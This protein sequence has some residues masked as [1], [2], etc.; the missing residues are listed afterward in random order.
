MWGFYCPEGTGARDDLK[1]G[2]WHHSTRTSISSMVIEPIEKVQATAASSSRS[3]YSSLMFPYVPLLICGVYHSCEGKWYRQVCTPWSIVQSKNMQNSYRWN[4]NMWLVGF[5]P[6]YL[7][8]FN[9]FT[10]DILVQTEAYSHAISLL[11]ISSAFVEEL[12]TACS[13]LFATKFEASA[14]ARRRLRHEKDFYLAQ[15]VGVLQDFPAM[16]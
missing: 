7:V 9:I 4:N 11:V 16:H 10:L 14:H 3:D 12:Q 15:K 13:F 2:P 8:V 1:Q 6:Q 5:G